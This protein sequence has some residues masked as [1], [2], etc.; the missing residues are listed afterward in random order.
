MHRLSFILILEF[1]PLENTK[2]VQ[3][4]DSLLPV[5]I[6]SIFEVLEM[7]FTCKLCQ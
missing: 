4:W 1:L 3:I 5:N 2:N 6:I 7:K